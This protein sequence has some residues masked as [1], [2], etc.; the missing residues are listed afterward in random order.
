MEKE[1]YYSILGITKEAT[2]KEIKKAYRDLSKKYHPDKNPDGEDM[3]KKI[4]E[5]YSVLSDPI[6]KQNYDIS[7]NPDNSLNSMFSHMTTIIRA[8]HLNVYLEESLSILELINGV[9]R[10]LKYT[11][12]NSSLSE[13][14][15]EEKKVT[16]KINMSTS[17]YPMIMLDDKV[18]IVLKVKGAGSNQEIEGFGM[19]FGGKKTMLA[20]GDLYIK[21]NIDW[22]DLILSENGDLIHNY[23]MQLYDILFN[24]ENVLETVFNKKY[25]I[26]K[27]NSKSLDNIKIKIPKI[28]IMNNFGIRGSYIFKIIPIMPDLS[29]LNEDKLTSLKELLRNL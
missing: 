28:G 5:A 16:Y 11:I 4:T 9:N 24:D 3:F 6:K 7:G 23:E 2:D 19:G 29:K 26:K 15:T 22:K 17:T 10:T 20:S 21:I 12:T 27:I 18:G 8:E 13:S 14:K 1:T 25:K